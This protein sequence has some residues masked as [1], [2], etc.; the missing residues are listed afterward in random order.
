[1]MKVIKVLISSALLLGGFSQ[2]IAN[3][4]YVVQSNT[5]LKSQNG[6]VSK[7]FIGVPLSVK[8]DN[9]ATVDVTVKG[10]QDGL[11]VYSTVKKE[12]LIATL[13]KDFQVIKK[14]GKEVELKGTVS[15]ELLNEDVEAV[16]DE[17]QEFYYEMCSVCHAPPLI[18]HL[19]MI[20]WDA[21]FPSMKVRTTLDE[22]EAIEMLR[23]LKSN[24][25]NGL[26]KTK[27]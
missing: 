10:F 1:M 18:E 19:S 13:E 21:I 14:D 2:V 6:K 24:A 17:S 25:A 8:K 26:I 12:L 16:W 20:E 9:G 7:L 4:L 11:N 5:E 3:D 23:Y 27:H 22:E 15:K